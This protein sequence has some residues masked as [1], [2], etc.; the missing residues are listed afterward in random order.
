M[1]SVIIPVY[2]EERTILPI[3][4]AVEQVPIPKEII[5]VN[6]GSTDRTPEI[7]RQMAHKRNLKVLQNGR[8]LGKGAA[9]RRGL[10]VVSGEFVIIQDADLE[11]DPLDYLPITRLLQEGVTK[12]VYGSR[13]LSGKNNFPAKI[14][15]GNK[16]LA[17]FV[18]LLFGSHLTDES[19]CY[20]AF[21]TKLLKS[22]K[23]ECKGFEFCP[24]VTAKLLRAKY[25]I[26]EVPI[27]YFPRSGAEGKK[28]K[29]FREGLRAGWTLLKYRF[30]PWGLRHKTSDRG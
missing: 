20:K 19:T 5:I 17:W 23:L 30:V 8:N 11:N 26:H 1:L 22:L 24:E 6:D 13:F 18:N 9:I 7:L 14:Y 2:N 4:T 16:L 21:D 12:V 15:I 10:E 27:S 25:R 29:Y 3:V 28:L